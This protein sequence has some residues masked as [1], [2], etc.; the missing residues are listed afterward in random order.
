MLVESCS[1]K[2]SMLVA[3]EGFIYSDGPKQK[4][5]VWSFCAATFEYVLLH[6]FG[7]GIITQEMYHLQYQTMSN[8]TQP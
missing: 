4:E 6:H 2:K 1:N 7:T 3:P 5:H 8:D